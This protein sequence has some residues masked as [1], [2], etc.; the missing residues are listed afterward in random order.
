MIT[1]VDDNK[2]E[3]VIPLNH[4]TSCNLGKDTNWCTAKPHTTHFSDYLYNLNMIIVYMRNKETGGQWGVSLYPIQDDD[5]NYM[6][7]IYNKENKFV[8]GNQFKQDT[9]FTIEHI[10]QMVNKRDDEIRAKIKG[11]QGE[12]P[13]H[14]I[15]KAITDNDSSETTKRKILNI[16]GLEK[17]KY[18]YVTKVLNHRWPE[19]EKQL[20]KDP[21]IAFYYARDFLHGRWPEAEKTIMLDKA[22]AAKYKEEVM[23]K[24]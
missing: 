5:G 22:I 7:E 3:I 20:I 9:G 23:D 16:F 15:A 24:E 21:E 19:M 11:L 2:W 10:M 17:L 6:Y 8:S 1:L 18:A 14:I 12:D 13:Q 4:T